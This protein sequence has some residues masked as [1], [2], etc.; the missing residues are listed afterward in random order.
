MLEIMFILNKVT[1]L[2]LRKYH[3]HYWCL[4]QSLRRH[5]KTILRFRKRTL[6]W[7]NSRFSKSKSHRLIFSFLICRTSMNLNCSDNKGLKKL[8]LWISRNMERTKQDRRSLDRWLLEIIMILSRKV[9]EQALKNIVRHRMWQPGCLKFLKRIAKSVIREGLSLW[10]CQHWI[11]TKGRTKSFQTIVI[12][13]FTIKS[14]NFSI[15][16]CSMKLKQREETRMLILAEIW[17]FIKK[18]KLREQ[19]VWI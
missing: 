10:T 5:I 15:Q 6:V 3:F 13:T 17:T 14:E 12:F 18:T 16:K 11:K 4:T 1:P 8:M 9:W 19:K 7:R 2:L